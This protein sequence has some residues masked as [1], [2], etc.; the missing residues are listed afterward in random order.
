M[1]QRLALSIRNGI[2]NSCNYWTR[3]RVNSVPTVSQ[4][5]LDSG[6]NII[7]VVQ[8]MAMRAT[9][10]TAAAMELQFYYPYGLMGYGIAGFRAE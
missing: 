4:T 7:E 3:L 8:W 1:V 9:L 2:E 10:P 6:R 5:L